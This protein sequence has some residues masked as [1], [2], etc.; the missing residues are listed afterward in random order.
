MGQN[1]VPQAGLLQPRVCTFLLPANHEPRTPG[2]GVLG[3]VSRSLGTGQT[4]AGLIPHGRA[5]IHAD[6]AWG[7]ARFLGAGR[8]VCRFVLA[9]VEGDL[10]RWTQGHWNPL[11]YEMV[12]GLETTTWHKGKGGGRS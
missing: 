3:A 9:T 1:S 4:N 2:A 11:L 6:E 8:D 7:G 5:R 12:W 10:S